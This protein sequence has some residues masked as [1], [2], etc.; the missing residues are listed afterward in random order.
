MT[1]PEDK[2]VSF[3]RENAI[4]FVTLHR[5]PGNR[6]NRKLV[7]DLGTAVR[8]AAMSD[9]RVLIVRAEGDNFCMGG[10]FTEWPVFD[11]YAKRKE[12]WHL[13]NG[14]LSQL[15]NLSVPTICAVHGRANGFGF[16][17]ALHTDLILASEAAAFR[18]TEATIGVFPLGGGAQRIAERAGRS[19][20]SRIVL[21]AE[22]LP[23]KEAERLNIIARAIPAAEY[24]ST[25]RSIAESLAD[26]PT[27]AYAASKTVLNTWAA[28]G[29]A[30]ADVQMI[31][32]IP[33]I[34]STHDEV[35]GISSGAKALAAGTARP[36]LTFKG[37]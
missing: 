2:Y 23:A 21:L 4:G 17:I 15:E 13:S 33:A 25:V 9:I 27:R 30:A 19:V 1:S 26:G 34:L 8:E 31:E 7:E 5:P 28:G 16:E 20:A 3:S 14:V 10:D 32:L 18:F 36:V 29:L 35:E 24:E 22:D 37:L 12:R 11:T 6:A